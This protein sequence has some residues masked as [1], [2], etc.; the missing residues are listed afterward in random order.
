MRQIS[1]IPK[2]CLMCDTNTSTKLD[3]HLKRCTDM[4]C[5]NETGMLLRAQHCASQH[6]ALQTAAGPAAHPP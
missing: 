5:A 2:R 3:Q 4:T 6:H 1:A